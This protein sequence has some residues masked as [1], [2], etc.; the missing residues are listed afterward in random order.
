MIRIV[1]SAAL[2]LATAT[3]AAAPGD[4]TGGYMSGAQLRK[5]CAPETLEPSCIGYVA[6]ISDL[7]DTLVAARLLPRL[8]CIPDDATLGELAA[9]VDTY[10]DGHEDML[11]NAGADLVARAL[12]ST[13]VCK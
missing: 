10:L 5:E 12:S 4:V 7:H 6:A 3:A 9:A 11:G 8:W 1:P 2:L 13:Y